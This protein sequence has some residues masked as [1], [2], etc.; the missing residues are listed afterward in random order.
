MKTS[1]RSTF[2]QQREQ[3]RR[4]LAG[5]LGAASEVRKIDVASVDTARL[6]DQI[7]GEQERWE[8]RRAR[9]SGTRA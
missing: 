2:E 8:R 9:G 4:S 3:Y 5:S 6:I 1:K 7:E